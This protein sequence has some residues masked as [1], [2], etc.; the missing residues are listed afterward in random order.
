[1]NSLPKIV[2]QRLRTA[3]GRAGGHPDPDV[4]AGF[5]EQR[6]RQRERA[7][8]LEHLARCGDCRE[9]VSLAVPE[10]LTLHPVG[11]RTTW[12][13]WH[14]LRW[15]AAAACVVVVGAA[16]SLRFGHKTGFDSGAR[17]PEVATVSQPNATTP[18][19]VPAEAP[20]EADDQLAVKAESQ[21]APAASQ[22]FAPQKLAKK[23][24]QGA[25]SGGRVA[26]SRAS[27]N[28]PATPMAGLFSLPLTEAP[29][30]EER[31]QAELGVPAP[32]SATNEMMLAGTRGNTSGEMS[33]VLPG[34]AKDEIAE[35]VR[36]R[37]GMAA[38][39]MAYSERAPLKAQ[40]MFRAKGRLRWMVSSEGVLLRSF[41]A[42]K[43]WQTVPVASDAVF[44]TVTSIGSDV[45]AGG[46]AG[47]LYH[48]AD[49]GQHWVQVRPGTQ[50]QAL[51]ADIV[52]IEFSD[53][54]HGEIG[55]ADGE[56]WITADGGQ[57]WQKQ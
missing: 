14:V 57:S 54:Q 51:S 18:A 25:V 48:S 3:D 2:Q 8:V 33:Q 52:S 31:G 6:L 20:A 19:Q 42:G 9:V 39:T 41:D 21:S 37:E 13:S 4:L 5:A 12:M 17:Q 27:R 32:P 24:D 56:L 40:R 16:V 50:G 28:Q 45:W 30:G 1:M 10:A 49:G 23:L 7:Q 55:T 11:A 15:A 34:K 29:A 22:Q 44:R 26:E 38:G 53:A 36:A 47:A 43:A 35:Q 46:L